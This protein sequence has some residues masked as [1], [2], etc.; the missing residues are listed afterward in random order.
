MR[1]ATVSQTAKGKY[2][3]KEV[4]SS[5]T[6]RKASFNMLPVLLLRRKLEQGEVGGVAGKE[7]NVRAHADVPTIYMHTMVHEQTYT[8]A[9][10]STC[11]CASNTWQ[12][13]GHVRPR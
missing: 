12:L 11:A 1:Y 13:C 8:Y 10:T 5:E 4:I 3:R 6:R 7:G 2:S 9:S